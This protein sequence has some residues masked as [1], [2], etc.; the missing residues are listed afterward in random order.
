MVTLIK[1]L[2]IH[3]WVKNGYIFIPLVFAGLFTDIEKVITLT[4]V[5][6][7]FSFLASAVY[8]INDIID[9]KVDQKHPTK[10]NRPIAS[11]K[12]S[13]KNAIGI[14]SILF[15]VSF[16][17]GAIIN[18]LI[19][20]LFILYAVLNVL[21]SMRLK[22]IPIIDIAVLAFFY[23]IRIVIGGVA[24][25]IAL[26]SWLLLTFF[27]LSLFL[28]TGKRY[29]ELTTNGGI[30]RSVL[31]S[32]TTEFLT[33][34]LQTSSICTILFYALYST[35]KNILI[36]ISTVFVIAGFAYYFYSLFR[37]EIRE[38]PTIYLF[39]NK[40]I[41]SCVLLWGMLILCSFLI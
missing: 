37:K 30:S 23:V 12:V 9:K 29:V 16:L 25:N 11:G 33:Y 35:T 4:L 6:F 36:E 38:D 32:Y 34:I 39:K 26:S 27:F 20:A 17:T 19:L 28:G 2:R 41:I 21:Y 3:H 1:L 22:H 15:G 7:S 5:F 31:K 18:P 40:V 13:V 24:V 8:V 10:K 14:A